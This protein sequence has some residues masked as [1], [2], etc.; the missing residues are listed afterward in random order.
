MSDNQNSVLIAD[1][2]INLY[3]TIVTRVTGLKRDNVYCEFMRRNNRTDNNKNLVW[4]S[5]QTR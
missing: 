3:Q 5:I 2:Y 4:T 1:N